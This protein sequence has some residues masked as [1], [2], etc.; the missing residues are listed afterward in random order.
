MVQ[1]Y[2]IIKYK[3]LN[4]KI[5][6]RNIKNIL[7]FQTYFFYFIKHYKT[8]FKNYSQKL[9]LKVILKIK[10]ALPGFL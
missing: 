10:Q 4:I 5:I 3:T 9:F 8:I 2:R 1:T 6:F 7:S